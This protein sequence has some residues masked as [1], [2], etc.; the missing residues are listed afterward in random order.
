MLIVNTNDCTVL[1]ASNLTHPEPEPASYMD[2]LMSRTHQIATYVVARCGE[3]E[4]TTRDVQDEVNPVWNEDCTFYFDDGDEGIVKFQV[5]DKGR[6]KDTIIGEVKINL[7]NL[8]EQEV[9][10]F[11]EDIVSA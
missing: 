7:Y 5:I 11:F 1:E 8:K 10:H 9:Y 3:Q 6:S 2:Y 4:L